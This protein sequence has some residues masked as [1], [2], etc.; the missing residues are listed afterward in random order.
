MKEA[1]PRTYVK[2]DICF[3]SCGSVLW[4]AC[5]WLAFRKLTRVRYCEFIRRAL[6]IQAP[7]HSFLGSDVEFVILL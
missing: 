6:P 4:W 3:A 5:M 2:G 1:G 7:P